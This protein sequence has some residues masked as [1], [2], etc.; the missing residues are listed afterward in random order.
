MT[1]ISS[2][3][4]ISLIPFC[5]VS[6][7]PQSIGHLVGDLQLN[8]DAADFG[9]FSQRMFDVGLVF[10]IQFTEEELAQLPRW[11]LFDHK[12]MDGISALPARLNLPSRPS[13]DPSSVNSTLWT[14]IS[15]HSQA[16]RGHPGCRSLYLN[17]P[18]SHV[19][20]GMFTLK[21]LIEVFGIP[22]PISCPDDT[23]TP[24]NLIMI[25]TPF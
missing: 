20:P 14:L 10:N 12:I 4:V 24:K 9:G 1:F 15:C 2:T 22:N 17:R 11:S 18:T 25:G 3:L 5:K 7:H 6:D 21:G 16:K 8:I 13:N 23:P 19:T